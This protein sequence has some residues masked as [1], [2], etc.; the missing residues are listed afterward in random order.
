M[1]SPDQHILHAQQE[2]DEGFSAVTEASKLRKTSQNTVTIKRKNIN[3]WKLAKQLSAQTWVLV[4]VD[5]M[6]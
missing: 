2:T 5:L 4:N 3:T 1:R 6:D